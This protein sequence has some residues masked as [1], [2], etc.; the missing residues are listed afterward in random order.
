MAAWS[1]DLTV[2]GIVVGLVFFF[3]LN[4]LVI[5]MAQY[6]KSRINMGDR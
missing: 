4:V 2:A 3:R 6:Y 1:K 5:N